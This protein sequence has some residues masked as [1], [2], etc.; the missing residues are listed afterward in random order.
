MG[1]FIA[2]YAIET[3]VYQEV[4]KIPFFVFRGATVNLGQH[5]DGNQL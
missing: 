5:P 2:D 1:P 4:S 3:S